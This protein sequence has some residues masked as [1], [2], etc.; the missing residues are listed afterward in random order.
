MD[1]EASVQRPLDASRL[2][3]AADGVIQLRKVIAHHEVS[4]TCR[5][6]VGC[7]CNRYYNTPLEIP[8]TPLWKG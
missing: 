6:I 2:Q 5:S 3:L 8:L 1:E 4:S 7:Y